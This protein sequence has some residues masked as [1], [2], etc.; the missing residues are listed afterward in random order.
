MNSETI[1]ITVKGVP[2]YF[3]GDELTSPAQQAILFLQELDYLE[4]EF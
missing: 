1:T 3:H 2:H 4:A